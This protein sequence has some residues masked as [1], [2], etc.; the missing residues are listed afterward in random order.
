MPFT[1]TLSERMT[2]VK[3][4]SLL[5]AVIMIV[6]SLL[7]ASAATL[8]LPESLTQIEA[9]AFMGDSG[10]TDVVLPERLVSIGDRAFLDTPNLDRVYVPSSVTSIGEEAFDSDT[11]IACE[12]DSYAEAYARVNGYDREVPHIYEVSAIGIGDGEEGATTF[13]IILCTDAP[14]TLLLEILNPT[15]QEVLMTESVPCEG[16]LEYQDLQ[17]EYAAGELPEHFVVRGV[18]VD[19]AGEALCEPFVQDCRAGL[20]ELMDEFEGKTPD[21][22]GSGLVLNYGGE[23]FGVLRSDVHVVEGVATGDGYTVYSD[24]PLSAGDAVYL[25]AFNDLLLAASAVENEDGSFTLTRDEDAGIGDFYQYLNYS[26][27][28]DAVDAIEESGN[29]EGEVIASRGST[30]KKLH[31]EVN[32]DDSLSVV[33]DTN[34]NVTCNFKYDVSLFG[35]SYV[36]C[37]AW[38]D[39]TATIGASTSV[40]FGLK[41][42]QM[43]LLYGP[44][45]TAAPGVLI[46]MSLAAPIEIS[47]EAETQLSLTYTEHSGFTYDSTH[48]AR[49]ASD[50]NVTKDLTVKG[51]LTAEAGLRAAVGISWLSLIVADV[52]IYGGAKATAEEAVIEEHDPPQQPIKRHACDLCFDIQ[53][54]GFANLDARVSLR[55]GSKRKDF[56][57]AS[58]PLVERPFFEGYLSVINDVDSVHHGEI[59]G[60]KGECPNCEYRVKV[61]LE[62][63]VDERPVHVAVD[64]LVERVETKRIAEELSPMVVYLIPGDYRASG[65]LF[66]ERLTE[67]FTVTDAP[68]TVTLDGEMVPIDQE[69]FPDAAFRE[70]IRQF[71]TDGDALLSYAER[72][73]VTAL[74]DSSSDQ[75]FKNVAS[76]AGMEYF[77]CLQKFTCYTCSE[78]LRRLDLRGSK[79]LTTVYIQA[80]SIPEVDFSGLD[81][82]QYIHIFAAGVTNLDMRNLP[83][84]KTVYC[85]YD[86]DL[87]NVDVS[88]CPEL[89][90][91]TVRWC[92]N[93][94]SVDASNCPSLTYVQS[95]NNPAMTRLNLS[96]SNALETVIA[97]AALSSLD[98]RH[99]ANLRKLD[100]NWNYNMGGRLYLGEHPLLEELYCSA[101]QLTQLD[102]SRYPNLQVLNC[103]DNKLYRLDVSNC[104]KLRNLNCGANYITSIYLKACPLLELVNL[105]GNNMPLP[106]VDASHRSHSECEVD[107][108]YELVFGP[109]QVWTIT[110]VVYYS[111]CIVP[112][113]I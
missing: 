4:L 101:C 39:L 64:R 93:V 17:L 28:F 56:A 10:I 58:L 13:D 68:L 54:V 84:L 104:K 43:P 92:S 33:V 21:S 91:L 65:M 113:S 1:P 85:Q 98:V 60:G 71:D 107:V 108:D 80:P 46:E 63:D 55:L 90:S 26:S 97:H 72:S 77:P 99:C 5:L 23:G 3:K 66:G 9:E 67:D 62:D 36:A 95:D 110:P 15:Q 35:K 50:Y 74:L 111:D 48:G 52:G 76:F 86:N 53:V 45:P 96:D 100:C 87:I 81:S 32:F 51:R 70:H 82:L 109:Y 19:G 7:G 57:K 78:Q 27:T 103:R 89:N 8:R 38:M 37:E 41:D 40:G 94:A 14:C 20:D 112:R 59:V 73:A 83:S 34:V 61:I 102:V 42:Y 105:V 30:P 29:Y 11:V 25:P 22:F 24:A 88:G 69:H 49:T 2:P 31:V 79:S 12:R 16:E 6:S 75:Y 106:F 47:A 44:I 18:L